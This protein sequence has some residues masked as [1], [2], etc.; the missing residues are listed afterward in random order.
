MIGRS[1]SLFRHGICHHALHFFPV[2]ASFRTVVAALVV[3]ASLSIATGVAHA[4]EAGYTTCVTRHL[5]D[6]GHGTPASLGSW[7]QLGR[8]IDQNVHQKG[9]SPQSQVNM[10]EG[11]GWDNAVANAVVQCALVFSPI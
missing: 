1:P 7:V 5:Q 10:V 6:L 8:N 2:T 3:A 9:A 4:D 11:L